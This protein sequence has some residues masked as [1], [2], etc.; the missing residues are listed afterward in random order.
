MVVH[1]A[2]GNW[3]GTVVNALLYHFNNLPTGRNGEA[4]PGL[5]HRIDKDTSGLLVIAKTEYAMAH[6]ARQFFEHTTERTYYALIWGIPK[7]TKGTIVG[8][9]GRS[10]RDRKVMAVYTDGS[11]GKH[12]VTHYEVLATYKYVSL[13]KCNLETGRTHQIRAHFQFLGHPLF[14]DPVYG[15]DKILRGTT[16]GSYRAFVEHCLQIIPRQALH[17][18][19]LGFQH[20][21][22][23]QWLQFDSELPEDFRTVLEKWEKYANQ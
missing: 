13:I 12:A 16:S 23:K 4:R 7:E 2:Y 5:I 6:V 1:P 9:I 22:T 8:H 17:A 15:G 10:A 20:P 3:N 18:K 21:R 14:G 11:Q 19:S